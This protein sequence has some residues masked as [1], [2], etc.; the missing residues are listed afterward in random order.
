MSEDN[1]PI[2]GGCLCGAVRYE[3]TEEPYFVAYC[4]CDMCKR[5]L[6]GPFG[7][8]ASFRLQAFTYIQ[9]APTFYQSSSCAKR[10]FCARCGS[11]LLMQVL[12]GTPEGESE[13]VL[14]K[15]CYPGLRR[16]EA[17][18][19]WIGSLDHPENFE[20][21]EHDCT[22]SQLPWLKI[23]DDLPRTATDNAAAGT[24]A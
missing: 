20:P 9:G 8:Y 17:V 5:A 1:M 4:H 19:L 24:K 13:S 14:A 10:G 18:A 2:T 11:P 22:E 3:V 16:A 15:E 12:Q 7:I 23:G 6:G 21:M